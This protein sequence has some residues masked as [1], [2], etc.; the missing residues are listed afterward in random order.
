M[1]N[2][3]TFTAANDIADICRTYFN[4]YNLHYF[5][6]ARVYPDGRYFCLNTEPSWSVDAFIKD[7]QPV[8]NFMNYHATKDRICLPFSLGGEAFGW[9]N[10]YY[11]NAKQR[12]GFNKPLYIIKR[13]DTHIDSYFFDPHVPN[14]ERLYIEDFQLF[15][16][17][18][19][20]FREQAADIINAADK[21]PLMTLDKYKIELRNRE[22][23]SQAN[24][25]QVRKF[26][27]PKTYIFYYQG[28]IINLTPREYDCLR[29]LSH[30]MTAKISAKFLGI[31]PKTVE[32]HLSSVKRKSGLS[33]RG[34]L[35]DLF[36]LNQ[37]P[38]LN[39][40]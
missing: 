1:K 40:Y 36:E 2:H 23:Q 33:T 17:F 39:S 35:I 8:G 18:F 15:E 32:T 5:N 9:S 14:L 6:L 37:L 22:I 38:S 27:H 26:I 20:Y 11:V 34:Q 28:N 25:K 19:F 7:K 24:N 13:Y 30:G 21:R 4:G 3:L 10:E 29:N 16:N 12:Y 31:S